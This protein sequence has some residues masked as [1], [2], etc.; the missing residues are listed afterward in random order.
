MDNGAIPGKNSNKNWSIPQQFWFVFS[1][2]LPILK[3]MK[4]K[5]GP[6]EDQLQKLVDRKQ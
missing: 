4:V 2:L 3:L 5:V 1:F 6:M